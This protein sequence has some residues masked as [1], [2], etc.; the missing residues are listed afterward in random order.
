MRIGGDEQDSCGMVEGHWTQLLIKKPLF[1]SAYPSGKV[2]QV[3][4]RQAC[5]LSSCR[6]GLVAAVQG[7]DEII[8]GMILKKNNTTCS[9]PTQTM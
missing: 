3:Q 4:L 8:D 5:H 1:E 6:T 7:L 9:R 2:Y